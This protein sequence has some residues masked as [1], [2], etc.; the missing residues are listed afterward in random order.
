MA[1]I[2]GAAVIAIGGGTAAVL[3]AGDGG[4]GASPPV[5][6]DSGETVAARIGPVTAAGD[7][8]PSQP[9]GTQEASTPTETGH[10]PSPTPAETQRGA[11]TATTVDTATLA[12]TLVDLGRR[13]AVEATRASAREQALTLYSDPEL[14]AVMRGRA[15]AVV[16]ESYELERPTDACRWIERALALDPDNVSYRQYKTVILVGCGS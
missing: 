4:N 8:G 6:R 13:I 2:L 1:V 11:E 5:V 15:A 12:A 14:P 16:A 10:R 3:L 7:T 9:V